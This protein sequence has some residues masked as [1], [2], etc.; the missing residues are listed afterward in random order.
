MGFACCAV[1]RYKRTL[2][3]VY[4]GSAQ[5]S[6]TKGGTVTITSFQALMDEQPLKM[7]SLMGRCTCGHFVVLYRSDGSAPWWGTCDG[8]KNTVTLIPHT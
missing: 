6:I 3:H 4:N 1:A 7:T 8:C 2:A 5:L